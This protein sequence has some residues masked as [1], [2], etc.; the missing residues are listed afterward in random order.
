M[1]VEYISF[2]CIR[3][4]WC[5]HL[6][7]G[8]QAVEPFQLWSWK[9][10]VDLPFFDPL[11]AYTT[12]PQFLGIKEGKKLIAVNSLFESDLEYTRSRGL[13]VHPEHRGRGL[14]KI[15]LEATIEHTETEWLWTFPR[16]SAMPCYEAVGFEQKS[17]WSD[18]GTFGPNCVAAF[19]K[20]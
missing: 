13:W 8:R 6:W 2:D 11:I 16:K 3:D 4:V 19:R 15:I 17:D 10:G 12:Y 20:Y 9:T 14:G 18:M 5:N 1:K 7:K